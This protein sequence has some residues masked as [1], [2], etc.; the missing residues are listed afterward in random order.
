MCEVI[1]KKFQDSFDCLSVENQKLVFLIYL[2]NDIFT[3]LK[4]ESRNYPEPI[5]SRKSSLI[6]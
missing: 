2:C 4:I 1:K 6:T 5:I 3:R